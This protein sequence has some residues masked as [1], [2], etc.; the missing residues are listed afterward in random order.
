MTLTNMDSLPDEV[1]EFILSLLPPYKDLH[2]CMSVNKRWRRCVLNVAKQKQRNLYRAIN[3]FDVRWERISPIEMAPTIS[4]RYSHAAVV[5]DNSMFVFGGCTCAMTTFNDLWRLDLSKRQ[6]IRPLAMGT[7]PSPKACSSMVRFNHTLVLFGGWTYPPSYPLYQSWHLFNE[8]HVYD[9]IS[10]RWTLI[11]TENTPPPVAGHSVSVVN[12]DMIIFGGLQKPCN[13]VH[14]EKSSDIWRLNLNTWTWHKQEVENGPKPVGRFGQTQVVIDSKNLLILGGSGEPNYHYCDAWILNMEGELWTWKKVEILDKN[15]EPLNIWSSPGCKI[16]D[17]IVV[18][19]RIKETKKYPIASYYPKTTWN[20]ESARTAP[21]DSRLSRIDLANRPTD[22]D[23]NVNG[24]RGTLRNPRRDI[25]EE[26]VVTNNV[27]VHTLPGSSTLNMAAFNG[28]AERKIETTERIR[29]KRLANLL[30]VE[31]NLTKGAY[32]REKKT[33]YLGVYVLDIS[34][35]LEDPPVAVWLQPKNLKNG[36]EETI[37]YTLV[38]GK[39]ELVMFG[40][41]Q[42]DAH[43]IGLSKNLSSQISNS[44]HFITAPSYVI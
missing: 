2:D 5:Y 40:G 19:N 39:S 14:C 30:K 16:D 33:H 32:K 26:S 8:L 23:E 28:P 3:E 44:L 27:K 25:D 42:K 21:E 1:L 24:K 31:E 43:L 11:P 9:I 41:I 10:N 22:K 34:R 12:D 35:V 20:L 15:N 4:K 17:K 29:E 13:A 38:K 7:Y 36:P 37:L 18:L 6:W